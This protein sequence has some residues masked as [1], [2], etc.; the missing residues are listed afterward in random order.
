VARGLSDKAIAK[1]TGIALCTVENHIR[2]AAE[3]ID[4]SGRP[5]HKLTVFVLSAG[6][7]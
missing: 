6:D 7:R 4:G 2:Q 5:R 1:Q 3:R